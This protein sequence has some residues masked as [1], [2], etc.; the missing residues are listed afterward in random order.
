MRRFSLIF[1]TGGTSC[2][3]PTATATNTSTPTQTA[4]NTSTPTATATNTFTPTATATNTFTPTNTST[5]TSTAT[6]TPTAT[7]TNTPPAADFISGTVTYGNAIGAPAPPRAVSGV[8]ISGAGSVNVSNTTDSS[9]YYVLNGFG[10]GSY[11]ITPSKTGGQNG[12]V[13]AFDAARVSQYIVGGNPLTAAQQTVAD[14]SSIGGISSFDAALIPRYAASLE[15]RQ[16]RQATGYYSRQAIFMPRSAA[17]P[18]MRIM[19]HC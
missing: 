8:L 7:A 4:T 6:D 5:S 3:T 9:G 2:G 11:T 15:R 18:Q 19:P 12:S 13:T 10:A 1:N 16:E 17:V 14:V